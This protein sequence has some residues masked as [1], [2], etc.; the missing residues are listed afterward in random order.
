MVSM[1]ATDDDRHGRGQPPRG[2]APP[3]PPSLPVSL[4]QLLAMQ[5]ELMAFACI[6]FMTFGSRQINLV[7]RS[8]SN[9]CSFCF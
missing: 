5:N 3:P 4:E 7:E 8:R 2:N 1:R 9:F 6:E